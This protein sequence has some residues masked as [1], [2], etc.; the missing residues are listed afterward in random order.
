MK[1]EDRLREFLKENNVTQEEIRE[2]ID[3]AYKIMDVRTHFIEVEFDNELD[4]YVMYINFI[5]K[6]PNILRDLRQIDKYFDEYIEKKD[7]YISNKQLCTI[8]L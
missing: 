6:K 2:Y 3:K 1:F 5:F 7:R 4:E 8:G